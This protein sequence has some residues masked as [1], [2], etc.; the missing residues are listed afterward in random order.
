M[1]MKESR[2]CGDILFPRY[3]AFIDLVFGV[4][5]IRAIDISDFSLT[6]L[7]GNGRVSLSFDVSLYRYIIKVPD[8]GRITLFTILN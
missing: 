5:W 7:P 8:R 6:N 4:I 2:Y 3:P 1:C